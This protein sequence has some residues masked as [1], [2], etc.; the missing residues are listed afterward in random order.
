M[1]NAMA[2]NAIFAG[3][4]FPTTIRI[5][6]AETTIA[7]QNAR[8]AMRQ[9]LIVPVNFREIFEKKRHFRPFFSL[10]WNKIIHKSK[11]LTTIIFWNTLES[12]E[13]VLKIL[14]KL[15]KKMKA[16]TYIT[17]VLCIT[18]FTQEVGFSFKT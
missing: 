16:Q 14:F 15:R 10:H 3:W 9:S 4:S 6:P 1:A 11:Y 17:M 12:V 2:I 7:C 13:Y 8:D 18:L 5:T